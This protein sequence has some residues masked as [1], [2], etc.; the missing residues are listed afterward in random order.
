[1]R[2]TIAILIKGITYVCSLV[3][4]IFTIY[5]F[6]LLSTPLYI[7][8]IILSYL[9]ILVYIYTYL[10]SYHALGILSLRQKGF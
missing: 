2:I 7:S 3:L 8:A 6:Y 9:S 4:F 1:M 5:L 10:T